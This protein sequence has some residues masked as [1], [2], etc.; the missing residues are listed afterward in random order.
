[1]EVDRNHLEMEEDKK[2]V[3]EEK[4]IILLMKDILKIMVL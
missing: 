1:M 4:I 3:M 2:M